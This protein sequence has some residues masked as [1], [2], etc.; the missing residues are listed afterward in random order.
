MTHAIV[1]PII[2]SNLATEQ[3]REIELAEFFDALRRSHVDLLE[4]RGLIFRLPTTLVEQPQ[5]K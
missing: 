3:H 4:F 2:G 1:S 5:L